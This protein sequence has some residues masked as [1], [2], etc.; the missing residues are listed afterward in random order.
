MLKIIDPLTNPTAHGGE[1]VRRVRRGDP[2]DAGLRILWQAAETGWGPTACARAWAELMKRLGYTL[3][4]AQGGDWGA[5]VTDMMA[6]QAPPGLIGMHTNMAGVL[7]AD[8]STALARNVL[9]AGPPPPSGL[10]AEE[11]RTYQQLNFFFTKGVGYGVEMGTAAADPLRHRGL[12]GRPG[13]LDDQPRRR[14]AISTSRRHS[15]AAR[16]AT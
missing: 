10:S 4:V 9:G 12:A 5:I 13:G 2:V 3:Y 14:R 11:S 15:R 8:V 16:L 1:R 6:A 7:P